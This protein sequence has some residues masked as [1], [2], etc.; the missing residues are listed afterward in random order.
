LNPVLT[1]SLVLVWWSW[2][3]IGRFVQPILFDSR[4]VLIGLGILLALL[5]V[6]LVYRRLRP[7]PSPPADQEISREIFGSR[8]D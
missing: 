1:A 5:P 3:W 7:L 6:R 8:P 4:W 2:T